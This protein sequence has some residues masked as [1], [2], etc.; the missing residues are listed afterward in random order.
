[1]LVKN[2]LSKKH[3]FFVIT[4]LYSAI[5]F[6][7]HVLSFKYYRKAVTFKR[8]FYYGARVLTKLQDSRPKTFQ[9][10]KRLY[11]QD[12][13]T[14]DQQVSK[15]ATFGGTSLRIWALNAGLVTS[16]TVDLSGL[17]Q[18]L[19]AFCQYPPSPPKNSARYLIPSLPLKAPYV[20]KVLCVIIII[21]QRRTQS[22]LTYRQMFLGLHRI[23]SSFPINDC[24]LNRAATY[25]FMGKE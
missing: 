23:T 8:R 14:Q 9:V 20:I 11:F 19:K 13:F 7:K 2:I 25:T 21:T 4:F 12:I 1:M 22:S 5:I 16:K 24:L 15:I 17:N 6:C 18:T 3:I 10:L